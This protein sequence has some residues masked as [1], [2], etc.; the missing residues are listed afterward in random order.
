MNISGL[1]YEKIDSP[2][3]SSMEREGGLLGTPGMVDL[4]EAGRR[5]EGT[6]EDIS[7]SASDNSNKVIEG[8][9]LENLWI[10][11]WIKSR[12]YLPG[13]RGFMLDGKTGKIECGNLVVRG[14]GEIGGWNIDATRIYSDD[15]GL[16][17]DSS[18]P[19]IESG[20]YVSGYAGA[21]VHLSPDLLEVGNIACRG[22]FRSAVMQYNNTFAYAGN[23]IV[24]KGADVLSVD[25]TVA[26][27]STIEIENDSEASAWA[28]GDIL[29]LDDANDTEWLEVASVSGNVY[30][31]NRDEKGDYGAG[32]NPSW[33]KGQAVVNYGQSGDG[34]VYTT[35]SEA[36][37]PYLSIF[38]HG[39]EPWLRDDTAPALITRLRIGNLNGYLGYGSD[40]YGIGIGDATHYLKYDPTNHLRISGEIIGGSISIGSGSPVPFIVDSAGNTQ[41]RSLERNDFH[42]FTTFESVDGYSK[43]TDGTG[44][45]TATLDGVEVKTGNVT[46][47][48]TEIKKALGDEISFDKDSKFKCEVKIVDDDWQRIEIG[49]GT[50]GTYPSSTKHFSFLV[51]GS[52]LYAIMADG[53]TSNET[54]LQE[55]SAGGTYLLEAKFDASTGF[56]KFYV[57]GSLSHTS[58]DSIT[59][60]GAGNYSFIVR[61]RTKENAVK[62]AIVKWWDFWQAI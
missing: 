50:I 10:S 61:A 58:D 29:Q 7:E 17:L 51:N 26:D 24:A 25:M 45:I 31:C 40:L 33:K 47:N 6:I 48:D 28:V 37:A 14:V 41:V 11:S 30:T 43:I 15:D 49:I 13:K 9:N 21:G 39:G 60:T 4:G 44:T 1:N 12:S 46:D 3:D 36:N 52:T 22:I 19:K 34:G 16:V 27:N 8:Q 56:V 38:T 20:N 42:W 2:F 32:A 57:D 18:V 5:A 53:A 55:I 59:P 62:E 23:Q 35:A 54:E